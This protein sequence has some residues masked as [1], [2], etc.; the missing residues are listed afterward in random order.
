MN[1]KN[2]KRRQLSRKRI[3]EALLFF[4]ETKELHQVRVS[5]ICG[6]AQINRTTFYA[7][8]S[9][10]Y[11]LADS[12]R[13][14]LEKEVSSF[15]TSDVTNSFSTD[16]FLKLF[17]HIAENQLFY[18]LYFKLGYD[19]ST[20]FSFLDNSTLPEGI[21]EMHL[22]YHVEF[23]KSGLNALIKKWLLEGCRNSPL[24]M[25]DILLKEYKG[26]FA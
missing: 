17:Q 24:E 22:D 7:N 13:T 9:D 20:T 15:F 2:N 4:L 14:Q 26:R 10:I 25:C 8:F 19:N 3:Q 1:T 11:D 5:E 18:K 16:I 6:R 12:I 23:F 21:D